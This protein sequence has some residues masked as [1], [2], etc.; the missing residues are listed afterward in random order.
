MPLSF[1]A[2]KRV[3]HNFGRIAEV[4]PMPNLIEV[5]RASY[6]T[7]LMADTPAEERGDNGLEG[8]FRS[9]FPISDFS[10]TSSLEFVRYEFE[11]PKY[12]VDEC[13]QRGLTFAAPL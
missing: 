2:R 3:R 13:I 7:F 9:V 6:E 4:V 1:T 12:D 5:Q 8:V 10:E 11:E